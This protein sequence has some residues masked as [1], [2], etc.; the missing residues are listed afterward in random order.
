MQL[1]KSSQ[2]ILSSYFEKRSISNPKLRID[3][4]EI[5]LD[6]DTFNSNIVQIL[7]LLLISIYLFLT[8][9]EDSNN[10]KS[11]ALVLTLGV[12]Y[13]LW[14]SLRKINKT[15]IDFNE[16]KILIKLKFFSQSSDVIS[17]SDISKIIADFDYNVSPSNRRHNVDVHLKD[18]Q[19]ITITD[20]KNESDAEF[21]ADY[22]HKHIVGK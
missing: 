12:L 10:L 2:E 3:E 7:V 11:F 19:V 18:E 20:S 9:K 22:L 15:T 1:D 4:N 16:R 21:L 5:I 8:S 13:L 6:G 17:F 14:N